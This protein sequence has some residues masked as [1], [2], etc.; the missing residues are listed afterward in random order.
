MTA[1]IRVAFAA[2][3]ALFLASCGVGDQSCAEAYNPN[4]LNDH[5]PY[6]PP[7]GPKQN[8]GGP[9]DPCPEIAKQTGCGVDFNEVFA[10]FEAQ[11]SGNCTNQGAG[12]HTSIQKGISGWS[13]A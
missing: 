1:F 7:G 8:Q 4:D 11:A 6:G 10:R 12:C 2:G 3:A 13:D 5:C 9:E